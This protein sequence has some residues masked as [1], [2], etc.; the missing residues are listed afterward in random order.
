MNDTGNVFDASSSLM[1][2]EEVPA[3]NDP[4]YEE[5]P[6]QV[7]QAAD[8]PD[9]FITEAPSRKRGF[10]LPGLPRIPGLPRSRLVAVAGLLVGVFVV[11]TLVGAA[12]GSE[13]SPVSPPETTASTQPQIE[14][15]GAAEEG[16]RMDRL[17]SVEAKRVRQAKLN[18]A[19]AAEAQRAEAK[20]KARKEREREREREK[21][22][23]VPRDKRADDAKPAPEPESEPVYEP[24]PT[25]YEPT[26]VAP[27]P[28]PTPAPAPA[29]AQEFGIEP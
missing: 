11:I 22:R 28:A 1:G 4:F 21:A 7:L 23:V 12:T 29:P 5:S 10:T 2:S 20:A 14:G 9:Y 15:S 24:E 3:H 18:A 27:P 26:E 6:T 17:V 25:Y 19:A 13:E 16:V 8:E